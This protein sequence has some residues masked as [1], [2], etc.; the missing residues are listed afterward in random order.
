MPCS[1]GTLEFADAAF[2]GNG[3]HGRIMIGIERKT[4]HDM[5][6]CIDDARYSAHQKPGMAQ[7]YAK[8]FLL[9]EGMWKPHDPEGWLMEGFQGGTSWGLCRYRSQRTLYSK[10]YRYLLSV[11]LSGVIITF[12][13]DLVQTAWNICEIYQYFQKRWDNHTALIQTQTLNIPDF[14]RKPS[15]V[16]R[17]AAELEGIGV[18]YSMEAERMFKRPIALANSDEMDWL[19][20]KGVGPKTALGI[21][22]EIRGLK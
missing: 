2:E 17:W 5:L 16:R 4:L 13:R 7:M 20:L 1:K 6:A 21:I 3:P 18:K 12:S 14:N 15:L 19:S 22:R 11:S 9:V 8:S 10:L